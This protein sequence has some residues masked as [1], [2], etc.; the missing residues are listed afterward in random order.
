MAKKIKFKDTDTD[1]PIEFRTVQI[2][3]TVEEVEETSVQ[4]LNYQ[5]GQLDEQMS[6]MQE[7]RAALVAKRQEIK[8]SLK[9]K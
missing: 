7:Q 9:I 3:S 6:R 5:I 8:T 4:A 2:T 1:T